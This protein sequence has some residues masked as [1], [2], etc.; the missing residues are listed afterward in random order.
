VIGSYF[1]EENLNVKFKV[2]QAI[3]SENVR[4]IKNMFRQK[5]CE[6]ERDI[7]YHWF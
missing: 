1:F 7:R 6:F 4:R 2:L 5:F 3:I